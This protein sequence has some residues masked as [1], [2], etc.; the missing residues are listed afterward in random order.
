MPL[1]R[2]ENEKP[3]PLFVASEG[4]KVCGSVVA[5]SRGGCQMLYHAQERSVGG[6]APFGSP[7]TNKKTRSHLSR[8]PGS[9]SWA[10]DV[11]GPRRVRDRPWGCPGASGLSGFTAVLMRKVQAMRTLLL[12]VAACACLS[13]GSMAQALPSVQLGGTL[14][15][16]AHGFNNVPWHVQSA[17][18]TWTMVP[19]FGCTTTIVGYFEFDNP[20]NG[21]YPDR[22]YCLSTV[23]R[24][25]NFQAPL[26][27]FTTTTTLSDD[28]FYCID[29]P[30]CCLDL[31][32]ID[33]PDYEWTGPSA[34]TLTTPGSVPTQFNYMVAATGSLTVPNVDVGVSGERH[35]SFRLVRPAGVSGPAHLTLPVD[36]ANLAIHAANVP[37]PD[38]SNGFLRA[39]MSVVSPQ[40]GSLFRCTIDQPIDGMATIDG[41]I[42]ATLFQRTPGATTASNLQHTLPTVTIPA[43]L[44]QVNVTV[45]IRVTSRTSIGAA[46]ADSG[47]GDVTPC[48][49]FVRGDSNGDYELNVSDVVTL[50]G[51]L[52]SQGSAPQPIEAGDV[53]N[54]GQINLGDAVYA[55]GYLFGS[56]PPPAEPFLLPACL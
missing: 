32:E 53:N 43:S 5:L 56:G 16:N 54:D 22:R 2:L 39:E 12:C 31:N 52:F 8:E 4:S 10:P 40:L 11:R 42:P 45:T 19:L 47:I 38:I 48:V 29:H 14:V 49:P 27:G 50:L 6:R 33:L 36:L 26:G 20:C 35:I 55:L 13:T 51:Y 46:A 24:V 41:N 18:P 37:G 25:P 1:L 15:V 3:P 23:C 28:C 34:C 9:S 44:N 7:R 21:S 17:S 30:E